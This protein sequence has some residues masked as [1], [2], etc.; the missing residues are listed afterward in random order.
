MSARNAGDRIR[1]FPCAAGDRAELPMELC[2]QHRGWGELL[3]RDEL[4]SPVAAAVALQIRLA[5]GNLF[6]RFLSDRRGRKVTLQI[7]AA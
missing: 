1:C 3:V 7:G 4:H 5:A 2:R 6:F